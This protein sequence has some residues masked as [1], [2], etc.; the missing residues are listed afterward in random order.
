MRW[1]MGCVS[2]PILQKVIWG[3][4]SEGAL[5]AGLSNRTA[6]YDFTPNPLFGKSFFQL[7]IR[8]CLGE[9]CFGP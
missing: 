9:F 2:I 8:S 4:L 7:L 3:I 1:A 5:C 6:D